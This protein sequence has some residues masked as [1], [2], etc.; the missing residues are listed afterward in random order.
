MPGEVLERLSERAARR[1]LPLEVL[2]EITHRCNLPCKH[3]YLPDHEDHGE[4]T[5]AEIET[6]FDQLVDVG[7]VFL[8]LTGG[9]VC[10]RKDFL[11][12]LDAAVERGFVVKVLSNATM[13]TDEIAQHLADAGVIEVSISLYGATPEIHDAV[14]DQPGSFERTMAGVERLRQHGLYI[15]FKTPLLTDNGKHAHDIHELARRMNAPCKFDMVITPQNNGNLSPLE[16]QLRQPALVALMKDGP[17][18]EILNPEPNGPGPEPCHAGRSFCSISPTGDILPCLMMPV[19]VGN[20]REQSF[21][22]IWFGSAFLHEVRSVTFETLTTCR[23]C[24]VK[25]SCDRCA[26]LAVMRS[27]GVNGC[28]FSAKQVAKARVAAHRLRVIQ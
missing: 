26:G 20:I 13:I 15:V 14:T 17:L 18:A 21:R 8:T 11:Q 10:S 5:L 9:E 28:D 22:E 25:G 6:M 27:Q 4:L 19:P 12:I 16:L 23:S 24:D 2:F 7:T 1:N 3:C